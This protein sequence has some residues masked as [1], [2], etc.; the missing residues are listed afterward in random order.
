MCG[1][2]LEDA[3][4]LMAVP[5]PTDDEQLLGVLDVEFTREAAFDFKWQEVLLYIAEL[6]GTAE[7]LKR[8]SNKAEDAIKRAHLA[9]M[10]QI[11]ATFAA[12]HE[13]L[14]LLNREFRH[15]IANSVAIMG[16]HAEEARRTKG[17]SQKNIAII[18]KHLDLVVGVMR[19][20]QRLSDRDYKVTPGRIATGPIAEEVV[21]EFQL[22]ADRAGVSLT[23]SISD[24]CFAMADADILRYCLE[25]LVRNALEAIDDRQSKDLALQETG[26]A[27]EIIVRASSEPDS[28]VIAV[29][30]TGI[31]FDEEIRKRLFAPL[32]TTKMRRSAGGANEGMGLYSAKRYLTELGGTIDAQ[33][34]G[35]FKG[36]SFTITLRRA[37]GA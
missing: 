37:D 4:T 8:E 35:H 14:V 2:L 30:D 34:A 36:A 7:T 3:G 31:G 17:P 23:C 20:L 24:S 9:E 22:E 33:S 18:R 1:A 27:Q 16:H 12:E 11:E 29:S 10:S 25:I 13:H 6:I 26:A 32:F 28:V 5:V 21:R 15:R 19:E